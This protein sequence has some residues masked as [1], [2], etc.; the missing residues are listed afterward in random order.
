[1]CN[2]TERH[3]V[4]LCWQSQAVLK[5]P[6]RFGYHVRLRPR[7]RGSPSRSIIPLRWNMGMDCSRALS[8]FFYLPSSERGKEGV[9]MMGK[10]LGKVGWQDLP[11]VLKRGL[12]W[13][14]S[15]G[16]FPRSLEA[17]GVAGRKEPFLPSL[18]PLYNGHSCP[19]KKCVITIWG[20]RPQG[21]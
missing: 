8:T 9:M 18:H 13:N 2:V 19:E 15:L 4:G 11:L 7:Q 10:R 5:M 16:L 17:G 14:R 12:A 20:H 6:V 1:M 3:S 21:E